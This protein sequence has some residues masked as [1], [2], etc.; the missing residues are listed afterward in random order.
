MTTTNHN[1]AKILIGRPFVS[2]V[3]QSAKPVIENP[4][5]FLKR[6]YTKFN[7][8]LF[9]IQRNGKYKLMGYEYDLR[10]YLKKYLYKQY[11]QWS[12]V[13]APNKTTL[14]QSIYG[15][16]DKIIEIEL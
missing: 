13:Y 16:I 6:N 10:P 12:E 3:D 8:N 5:E 7:G 1:T 11:G 9:N 15:A 4:I 2:H 14:R